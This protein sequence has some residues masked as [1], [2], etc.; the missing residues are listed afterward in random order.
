MSAAP[1]HFPDSI[2]QAAD[3]CRN[4]RF[5]KRSQLEQRQCRRRA[6]LI[7]AALQKRDRRSESFFRSQFTEREK[8][9]SLHC[10]APF[11]KRL[12]TERDTCGPIRER[13][14]DESPSVGRLALEVEAR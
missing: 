6:H 9:G 5:S 7:A 13:Q 10:G 12:A 4:C 8:G 11:L 2:L 3:E 14:G 1:P